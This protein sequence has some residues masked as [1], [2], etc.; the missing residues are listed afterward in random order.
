MK[1]INKCCLSLACLLGIGGIISVTKINNNFQKAEAAT[2]DVELAKLTAAD[3]YA[4]R[5]T[6]TYGN[7]SWGVTSTTKEL[8]DYTS[9]SVH[10]PELYSQYFYVSWD[11]SGAAYTPKKASFA[12]TITGD[13]GSG[14]HV[15]YT[16][17]RSTA[18][19]EYNRYPSSGY[20]KNFNVNKGSLYTYNASGS[21]DFMLVGYMAGCDYTIN[22]LVVTIY[23]EKETYKATITAG[24]GIESVFLSTDENATSGSAS[25]TSFPKGT[26]VYGFAV[27]KEGYRRSNS[28][29]VLVSGTADTAGCFFSFVFSIIINT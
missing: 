21:Y 23:G 9:T 24:T 14:F 20:T 28:S 7:F 29:W 27:L 11:G 8:Y 10:V 26:K 6:G 25:G 16:R 19:G 2:E 3:M 18:P 22:N 17:N 12:C 15:Y 5:T 13:V 1:K 4:N